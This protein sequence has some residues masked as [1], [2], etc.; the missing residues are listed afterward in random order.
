MKRWNK[1]M[2][3]INKKSK[4]NLKLYILILF[5]KKKKFSPT[6]KK[7]KWVEVVIL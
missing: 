5:E 7:K 6:L 2:F 3:V 4:G 1:K